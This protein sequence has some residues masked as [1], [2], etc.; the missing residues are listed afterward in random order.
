M[1]AH[2]I[3]VFRK[4]RQKKQEL[5]ATVSYLTKRFFA[6]TKTTEKDY[7]RLSQIR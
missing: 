7:K 4:W 5:K 2:I 6:N 3:P 1:T